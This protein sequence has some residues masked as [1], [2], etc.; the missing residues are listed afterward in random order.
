ML[1][2]ISEHYKTGEPL[3]DEL[4]A[5][6]L[7]AKNFGN[8]GTYLRQNFFAQYDMTLH[9][10]PKTPDS[11]KLYFDLT[12]KI[13]ALPLTKNT[14]PQASFG[15]IMGGYDAGYYGYLWS[16]VIAEDFFSM[17][18]Q[19]GIFNPQI[20]LKFRR[21]ILEKGGSEDEEKLVENFLGRPAQNGPFLR[22]IGLEE[23]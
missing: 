17:F 19:N 18:E 15:H 23:K 1:K 22:A 13:R 14:Y 4:I 20:G 8:G 12:K 21:E 6:M 3:P 2:K 10:A 11:T 16:E 7:K 5:R 9:T